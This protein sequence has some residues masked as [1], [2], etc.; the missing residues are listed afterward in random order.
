MRRYL[1]TAIVALILPVFVHAQQTARSTFAGT[2]VDSV[3]HPIANAEILI[4]GLAI[5]NTT[6]DKGVFRLTDITTGIHRVVVRRIGYGQLDTTIVFP[7]GQTVERRIT[8]GRIV[9]LDS[10]VTSAPIRD[11]EMAA[12]EEHRAR[13]FGRFLTRA[14]L[15]QKEGQSLGSLMQQLSGLGIVRGI[16]GQNWIVARRAPMTGCPPTK[17]AETPAA[18]IAAQRQTDA[19]LRSERLYYVPED[20]ET[21]Q[22]MA[23][24]CYSL[25]YLDRSLM[26]FGHP[27]QPFDLN[28]LAP[29]R[30]EAIEW[31]E[32]ATQVP[33]EY[34]GRDA[35]CG[36]AILH[37]RRR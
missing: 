20:Y 3:Q 10:I 32:S 35:Q 21:M 23:R 4:P 14:Q 29:G 7:E 27:T 34:N 25:V 22:G 33:A 2:V 17:I 13:G 15:E 9:T 30:L 8:L 26:N 1:T 12:F 37:T 28:S 19:C 6:N 11:L 16:G 31:F 18:Q 24:A 5:A 36:L